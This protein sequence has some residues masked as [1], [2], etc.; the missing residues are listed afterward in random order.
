M[1]RASQLISFSAIAVILLSVLL[2]VKALTR[3]ANVT[4]AVAIAI[5]CSLFSIMYVI[6]YIIIS[7]ILKFFVR[8]LYGTPGLAGIPWSSWHQ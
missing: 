4:V 5:N 1:L 7:W 2:G 6:I 8:P 3:E